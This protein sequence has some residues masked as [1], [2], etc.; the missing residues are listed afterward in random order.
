M[1]QNPQVMGSSRIRRSPNA[2]KRVNKLV[3][4]IQ[5]ADSLPLSDKSKLANFLRAKV[6]A[7]L[8]GRSG[9]ETEMWAIVEV[10][11]GPGIAVKRMRIKLKTDA[12]GG[13]RHWVMEFPAG[14]QSLPWKNVEAVS[15]AP[16]SEEDLVE[17]EVADVEFSSYEPQVAPTP[18]DALGRFADTPRYSVAEVVRG[19][20]SM[21]ADDREFL[22]EFL[23]VS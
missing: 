12:Q 18:R 20:S 1:K 7:K 9:P 17:L 6:K 14:F 8:A 22:R 10:H 19:D 3:S 23:G 15:L 4:L 13:P 11:G 16:V 2:R 21:R 5:E